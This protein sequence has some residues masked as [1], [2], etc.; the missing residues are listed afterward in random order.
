MKKTLVS[1]LLLF[2]LFACAR[3]VV[4][5]PEDALT[6]VSWSRTTTALDDGEF[7]DIAA[8]VRQSL[9]YYKKFPQETLFYFGADRI[10]APD[11][12]VPSRTSCSLPR[13]VR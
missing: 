1:T 10:T 2:S 13:T 11:M 12:A 5:K 7:R 6:Q 9:E 8:A 3:P 4:T